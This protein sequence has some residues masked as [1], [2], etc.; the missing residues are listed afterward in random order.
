[1]K[2]RIIDDSGLT[3]GHFNAPKLPPIT[4]P[5]RGKD[6]TFVQAT[7]MSINGS[8]FR[9][10]A[11]NGSPAGDPEWIISIYISNPAMSDV[12]LFLAVPPHAARDLADNLNAVADQVEAEI[13]KG[14]AN[15]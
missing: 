1:M 7:N 13:L 11:L 12:G 4:L 6:I 14:A 5:V 10:H 8:S 15:G 3:T 2:P 9:E